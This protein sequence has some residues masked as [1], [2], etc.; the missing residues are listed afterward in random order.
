MLVATDV[1]YDDHGGAVAA[2]VGFDAWTAATARLEHTVHL[3]SVAAYTSGEFW[4]RELPCLLAVLD[5][6]DPELVVVDGHV[7]LAPER[8][9]LGHYLWEALDRATPVVGVAKAP[10]VG[11]EP[12]EVHRGGSARPLLV[13]AIGT[14]AREAAAAVTRMHGAHRIPTLLKRVDHLCRGHA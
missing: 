11:G 4:R 12:V 13:T 2:A 6:L 8:P 1:S 3:P 5:G 14:D 10:F 9:G 7:W